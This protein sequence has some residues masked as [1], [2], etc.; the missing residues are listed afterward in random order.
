M[1]KSMPNY[2]SMSILHLYQKRKR[3]VAFVVEEGYLISKAAHK[4]NIKLSTAKLIVNRFRRDGTYFQSK[5][6][7]I[8]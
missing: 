1:S 8:E 6:E 5:K 2:P 3:L 4:L 7:K